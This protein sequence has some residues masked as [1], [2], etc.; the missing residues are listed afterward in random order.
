MS[1]CR[2]E[3]RHGRVGWSVAVVTLGVVPG[4]LGGGRGNRHANTPPSKLTDSP[5]VPTP[6]PPH[7]FP[8]DSVYECPAGSVLRLAHVGLEGLCL[9]REVYRLRD[10]MAAKFTDYC[11]NGFWFSPEMEFVLHA[12]EKSQE[13]RALRVCVCACVRCVSA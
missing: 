2:C 3:R 9:D 6:S 5:H 7:S 8:P 4:L 12:V 13:V 11:Y 10:M 1:W